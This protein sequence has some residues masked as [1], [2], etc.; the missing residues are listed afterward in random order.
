[1]FYLLNMKRNQIYKNVAAYLL[2]TLS[3]TSQA[4]PNKV[5]NQQDNNKNL[6]SLVNESEIREFKH[7][8]LWS[9]LP[10]KNYKKGVRRITLS[11]GEMPHYV[12]GYTDSKIIARRG[13]RHRGTAFD[14]FVDVHEGT[15]NLGEGNEYMTDAKACQETGHYEFG[16][17]GINEH[18]RI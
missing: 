1:M 5:Q 17:N 8:D 10:D 18:K 9:S 16:R 14:D 13:D 3:V 6:S 7:Y 11:A 2:T 12:Q 15:H 4:V